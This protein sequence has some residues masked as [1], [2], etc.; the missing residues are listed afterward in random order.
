[1]K[2]WIESALILFGFQVLGEAI[3]ELFCFRFPGAVFGMVLLFTALLSSQTL[4]LKVKPSSDALIKNMSLFFVP[5][6]VGIIA[7]LE[8]VKAEL[9]GLL[10][11]MVAGTLIT[12]IVS[13]ISFSILKKKL[14]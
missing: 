5:A 9:W 13:A 1:M 11:V 10:S 3:C 4:H 6:G 12:L 7:I 2:S 8:K 14:K